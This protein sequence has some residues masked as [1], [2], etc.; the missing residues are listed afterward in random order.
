MPKLSGS[1]STSTGVAPASSM[2]ATVAVAVWETVATPS[3]GPMPSAISPRVM[4]S[5]PLA[6][7]R[8][9]PAPVKAANSRSK[10]STSGPRI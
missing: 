10:A 1:T 2:A 3:P 9:K 5:V 6:T 4:A 8:A 7:P